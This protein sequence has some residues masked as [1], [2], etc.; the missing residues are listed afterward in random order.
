MAF[1][2]TAQEARK[3]LFSELLRPR[4][5]AFAM[6]GD[7]QGVHEA[8][9]ISQLGAKECCKYAT[10]LEDGLH[11]ITA[12]W[13]EGNKPEREIYAELIKQH[14]QRADWKGAE[15]LF[16]M[17]T[18]VDMYP[19]CLTTLYVILHLPASKGNVMHYAN[20]LR[21]VPMSSDVKLSHLNASLALLLSHY[22]S[23]SRDHSQIG[24]LR[25]L[26]QL[27]AQIESTST[28]LLK[29]RKRLHQK[30]KHFSTLVRRAHTLCGLRVPEHTG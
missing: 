10:T 21:S 25:R 23:L 3:C 19:P 12:H 27:L 16:G 26:C 18:Q 9:K 24:P 17:M 13:K 11:I 14:G 7:F 22:K 4:T 5:V 8:V 1:L 20:L 30:D 15:V 28:A 2:K 6:R 29:K